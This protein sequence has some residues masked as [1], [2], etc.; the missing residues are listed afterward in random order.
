MQEVLW[1]GFCKVARYKVMHYPSSY[2]LILAHT[3]KRHLFQKGEAARSDRFYL[4]KESKMRKNRKELFLEKFYLRKEI[5]TTG[6]LKILKAQ[7]VPYIVKPENSK[8]A[9]R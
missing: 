3:E 9:K 8:S 4:R 6:T 1:V 2:H 5:F 7:R